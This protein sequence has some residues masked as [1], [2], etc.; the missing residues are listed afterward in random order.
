MT[1]WH[2]LVGLVIAVGIIAFGRAL[3][4]NARRTADFVV[5][6]EASF[7]QS[8]KDCGSERSRKEETAWN[9]AF[10]WIVISMGAIMGLAC[11]G[12]LVFRLLA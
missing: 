2:N 8:A 4:S 1:I 6:Y 11:A 12:Q 10:G 9:K 3:L 5:D 7:P